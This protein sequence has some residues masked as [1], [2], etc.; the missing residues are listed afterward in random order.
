MST[1]PSTNNSMTQFLQQLLRIQRNSMEIVGKLTEVTKSDADTVFLSLE[2]QFGASQSYELPTIGALK[3]DITRIDNNFNMLIGQNGET[4][5]VRLADGSFRKIVEASLFKEPRKIGSLLVPSSFNKKNNWFFES[6]LN[7]LLYVSFDITNYVEYNT[8]QVSYKRLIINSTTDTIKQY[9]DASVKGRN[10]I[11]YDT[12]LKDLSSRGITYFVDEDIANL[13][14]SI[15]RYSGTFDVV[16][17]RDDIITTTQTTG[18]TIQEKVRKYQLNSL[19]YTDN[20]QNFKNTLTIKAGDKLEV[21]QSSRYEVVSVDS[22][23]NTIILKKTSG[24]E[25]VPTG[26]GVLRVAVDSFSIK[27]VQ[28]NV[29]F[30]ERQ[31][32]FIKAI[33][34]DTNLTTRDFSPGVAFYTNELTITQ[35]DGSTVSLD[36]FY[37]QE[38]LDFGSSIMMLAKEGSIPAIYGEYPDAPRLTDTNFQVVAVNSQKLDTSTIND[39]KTKISQKNTLS[40][41]ITQL[42]T[43]IENKRQEFNTSKFNSDVERQAV[44]N[45]LENLIRQK[46]STSNLY[47]SIIN[48]LS[49]TA[50]NTPAELDTAK[51]RV[52]GF[53]PIPNGKTSTRTLNQEVIQFIISYRYL[54]K[55]GTAPGTEQLDFID[56]NGEKVRGYF[57]NWIEMPTKVRTKIYDTNLGIYVW[58]TE[59]VEDGNAVNINQVDVAI[60]KGE[61]VEIR[62]KSVSEAGWPNNPL[63]SDWSSSIIVSFPDSL[64]N[65]DEVTAALQSAVVEETRVNF[66]QD[67]ASRGLDSHLSTSFVQ[68]DKYYPHVADGISSGFFNADGS[69]INLYQKLVT[70][71]NEIAKMKAII[72]KAKGKLSVYIV[73]PKGEKYAVSNN[74]LVDLFAGYYYDIVNTLPVA[75]QKG[76]ILTSVYKLIIQNTAV[77]PL[78]LVSLFPGGLE[79]D[80]P[81]SFGASASTN[82]DYNTSRKYDLVPISLSGLDASKTTNAKAYQASPFQS[83]QRLS[84]FVYL[85]GTDIG[86][87]DNLIGSYGTGTAVNSLYPDTTTGTKTSFVYNLAAG[88]AIDGLLNDF[89]VHI[90]HP[91]LTAGATVGSLNLPTITSTS[92]AVYPKLVHSKFFNKQSSDIDGKTQ[93]QYI[94]PSN[95]SPDD[96]YPTKLGFYTNDRYL[97]GQ[98]T[99]GSYLYLAPATYSDILVNGTDY[100]AVR[101]IE[102]GEEFQISIPII[103]QYRMTDFYGDG[104]NSGGRIG[105][106]SSNI[107]NLY[108][109]KKIGI[110]IYTKDET[111]FSFDVQISS[112][113]KVDSPSQTGISPVGNMKLMPRQSETF[114]QIF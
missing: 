73:D 44:Q 58:K 106:S 107:K 10:D 90:L 45:Q 41:E 48:D 109:A 29:G 113:Y 31:V 8:Q 22:S 83:A 46:T 100:R 80:L 82:I 28:L 51:Y 87:K 95:L 111:I 14:V 68:G 9:F 105:G 37:K 17:Y 99:C 50:K 11:D 103:F 67:L 5:T 62:I 25:S 49:S 7:P 93:T 4:V 112:K 59:N 91:D 27:E 39:L 79:Q 63:L 32:I 19:K 6:F 86:L 36:T 104:M 1:L 110:D 72:E 92:P 97:I 76:A 23:N 18:Q 77:S 61:K 52:R 65:D 16:S 85:R 40:A 12:L 101:E 66:N 114:N 88:V 84:Q 20:L 35:N 34:R 98:N 74:S 43:A 21:G 13:P 26:T 42:Q 2:D 81:A 108:Y 15:A 56:N 102:F 78:Q 33:D 30:D 96:S 57:S 47:A 24:T 53:F 55:D 60:S 3:N 54:R 94:I 70:M 69:I 64:G 75:Q 38:V 71:D 89:C